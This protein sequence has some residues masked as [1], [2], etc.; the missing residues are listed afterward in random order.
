MRTI[1][2]VLT[3]IFASLMAMGQAPVAAEDSV[4]AD[5][6]APA[7][8]PIH[9]DGI[10]VSKYQGNI[11]WA[12]IAANDSIKFVYIK[13]TEG[14]T[15]VD[16]RFER[17]I[18]EA[19][20]HGV[21]VG[22]YHFLRSSSTIADQFEN[23]KKHIRRDEQHYVPMIDVETKGKWDDEQLVDSLHA[24]AVMIYQHYRCAPII[25]T[26]SNFYNKYLSG[27]F[28]NYPLF[29]ARYT[30]DEPELNDGTNYVIWQ[31]SEKGRVPGIA[32]YVDL[33]RF[34]P[35]Y[36]EKDIRIN[37]QHI[38]TSSGLEISPEDLVIHSSQARIKEMPKVEVEAMTPEKQKEL[39]KMREQY[40]KEEARMNKQ[41]EKEA[42]KQSKQLAEARRK[43]ARENAKRGITATNPKTATKPAAK[44]GETSIEES[45]DK[46][47]DGV[48][49]FFKGLKSIFT[50][51]DEKAQPAESAKAVE[52]EP[53][54]KAVPHKAQAPEQ[55]ADVQPLM[56]T[57][58]TEAVENAVTTEEEADSL[59]MK[60]RKI[61]APK[62]AGKTLRLPVRKRD[63]K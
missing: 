48:S 40:D 10:D 27:M 59:G 60:V 46:V 42:A 25:Y 11:N 1:F 51:D 52:T 62:Q 23:I 39:Q 16:P 12:K 31:F 4:A 35:G 36:S 47:K 5:T 57:V 38:L 24:L 22:C 50:G 29:I 56:Q 54:K 19:R 13:A 3:T 55:K 20:K 44:S 61:S 49:S 7:P 53:A 37:S 28:T 30:G 63:D 17:N 58:A 45:V 18:R 41:R 34:G 9:Y 14:A 2:L 21:R 15:Y 33:N 32:G 6:V 26:Y 8:A 43:E